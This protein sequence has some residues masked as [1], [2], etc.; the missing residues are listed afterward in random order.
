[1]STQEL[2]VLFG[3]SWVPMPTNDSGEEGDDD[4]LAADLARKAG[5]THYVIV[6]DRSDAMLGI[7][8]GQL[9]PNT[10]LAGQLLASVAEA[11]EIC[12]LSAANH[13]QDNPF[14]GRTLFYL[15]THGTGF[16]AVGVLH[17]VPVLDRVGSIDEMLE[18]CRSF[19]SNLQQ[20]GVLL[21]EE[22]ANEA[23][24]SAVRMAP[25]A[26]CRWV[27]SLPFDAQWPQRTH[28]PQAVG[29]SRR[30]IMLAAGG[31]LAV[32]GLGALAGY[33]E[34]KKRQQIAAAQA[35][36]D[37]EI[38]NA[39]TNIA[40]LQ[41]NAFATASG[42]LAGPAA[43]MVFD[44]ARKM[45]DERAGFAADRLT[46]T[47]EKTTL[48][49]T[50]PQRR[51]TF[52]GFVTQGDEGTPQFVVSKLDNAGVQYPV[53]P[54]ASIA[55]VDLSKPANAA[56]VMLDLATLAQRIE[57]VGVKLSIAEPSPLLTGEQLNRLEL[58]ARAAT[59]VRVGTW[60]AT[61]PVDLLADMAQAMPPDACTLS[62]VDIIFGKGV[63]GTPADS[64]SASGRY[65]VSWA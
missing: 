28:A 62:Q 36:I 35:L 26:A 4:S 51:S 57:H 8:K 6:S 29:I 30:K 55:T 39:K 46:F 65:V 48:S 12:Y 5:G 38:V 20:S 31:A 33:R 3:T 54:W 60:T 23:L 10:R 49:Y 59:A 14:R 11:Q 32:V 2:Q 21:L 9:G 37:A 22:G 27:P 45:L 53:L 34:L 13:Q 19:S 58:A 18:E 16:C 40:K 41:A 47:P 42:A 50:R 43:R 64:F 61:G 63:D 44:F 15:G 24:A 7:A 25:A 17:G 56:N 1:M 52:A